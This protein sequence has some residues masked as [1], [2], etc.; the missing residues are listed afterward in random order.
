MSEASGDMRGR[1]SLA[2][3]CRALD[4]WRVSEADQAR[5]LM[6]DNAELASARA[7]NGIVSAAT[8]V[9]ASYILGIF[10]DLEILLQDAEIADGWVKRPNRASPFG[11]RSAL[12][13]MLD[14]EDGLCAVRR[15]LAAQTGDDRTTSF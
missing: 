14:G 2:A 1:A 4:H 11:G 8:V 10:G 9:R 12:D 7:R 15:Y 13:V 3:A 6:L 5:L